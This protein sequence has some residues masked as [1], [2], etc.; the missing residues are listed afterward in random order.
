MQL[1]TDKARQF[2]AKYCNQLS[3]KVKQEMEAVKQKCEGHTEV[4]KVKREEAKEEMV[5]LQRSL[6]NQSN[7]V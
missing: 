5:R 2:T 7:G 6:E 4:M 3:D 1:A